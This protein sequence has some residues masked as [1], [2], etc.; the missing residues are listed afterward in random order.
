VPDKKSV[1][2]DVEGIWTEIQKLRKEQENKTKPEDV[3]QE[4]EKDLF[5]EFYGSGMYYR[6]Y[7]S[8]SRIL[9]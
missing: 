4:Q 1:I 6:P 2:D 8:P 7:Y 3:Q 9:P 5:E